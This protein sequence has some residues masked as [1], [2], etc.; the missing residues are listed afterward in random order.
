MDW[1]TLQKKITEFLKKYRYVVLV[2]AV[3]LFLMALPTGEE[4][5]S[6][7]APSSKTEPALSAQQSLE[8]ILSQID[9]AGRVKVLLTVA[10][11]EQTIY[12]SDQD[13][14]TGD[15]SSAVRIE[16]VIVTDA[17]KAQQG[18]VRQVNPPVYLG[19]I[20]VCQG[21]GDAGVRLAIVEAV[22]SATGLGADK[23]TVLKM[24]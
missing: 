13:T 1:V 4:E 20:V 8:D 10:E 3:G 18:L 5:T 19:A 16:T 6:S 22:S 14:T 24:K 9:G 12:Q 17:E 23:I 21:G 7:P 2:L 11:G 15:Q